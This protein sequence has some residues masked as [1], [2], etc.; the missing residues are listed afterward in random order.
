MG[1]HRAPGGDRATVTLQL[2]QSPR[3]AE[4]AIV[5]VLDP[6]WTPTA[7]ERAAGHMLPIRDFVDETLHAID[8]VAETSMHLDRWAAAAGVVDVLQIGGTSF[9][10]YVRLR[11]WLWL[12]E[13]VVWAHVLER[14]VDAV[15]PARIIIGAGTD[16][17]LVDVARLG[18]AAGGCP[19][20]S[21]PDDAS[22]QPAAGAPSPLAT[23]VV[24]A[25]R[26][27]T[28]PLPSASVLRSARRLAR[29][30]LRPF[31]RSSPAVGRP[32]HAA[33]PRPPLAPILD[34]VARLADEGPRLL[35]V[36]THD[37]H[38]VDGPEGPRLMNP[39]LGPVADR[40]V[41]TSLE[42]I[43]LEWRVKRSDPEA[44]SRTVGPGTDRVL[45]QDAFLVD[46]VPEDPATLARAEAAARSI[47]SLGVPLVVAGVDLGP[48][49]AT[50]VGEDAVRWFPG[51]HRTVA[52]IERLLR[53]LRPAGVFIADE[54]HRQDWREATTRTGTPF[55]AMQHG[56]INRHH[57]GYIHPARPA[58]LRLP[59]RT[60]VF[61]R[62][63]LDRLVRDSVYRDDEVM[64]AGSP[65]LDYFRP[66]SVDREAVRA[67]LG[68]AAG[69]RLVVLSGTWGDLYR[70]FHYPAVLARIFDRPLPRVHLVVKQH[71]AEHDPGPYRSVI[72]GVARAGGFA[73]PPITVV[74]HVDLYALLA[75][76]DAHLGVHSTVLT[77]AVFVGTPNLLA[78]GIRGSDFLD[79]V[80][81]GV[82]IPVETGSDLLAALDAVAQGAI[83]TEARAAFLARQ[84][85]PGAASL[86]IADDLQARLGTRGG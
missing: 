78:A 22:P 5:L 34:K 11:H 37:R 64:V 68:V 30:V 9:W 81:A 50:V 53:V 49:L 24:A 66:G 82:A 79:Y 7:A 70:R 18:A 44:F 42:P 57:Q 36:G 55:I 51:M 16:A 31:R 41:G 65:R 28:A 25:S 6:A 13:R 21:D 60:Y 1:Q 47:S 84:F 26:P 17:A 19:V 77:E 45:P 20:A 29:R 52:R 58:S 74:Q 14:V 76:A 35:V 72:E 56:T 27:P 83:T 23:D 12:Q 46:D 67:E 3:D 85:E 71:P 32:T 80:A 43:H 33:A 86:R 15:R 4:N 8:P 48:T 59:D 38:L 10:Y 73:P 39:Y 54:Y 63:E 69:D 61:G 2:S 75:A 62:W 40:L